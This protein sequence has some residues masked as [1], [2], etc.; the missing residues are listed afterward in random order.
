[1]NIYLW[2][3]PHQSIAPPLPSSCPPPP[4]PPPPTPPHPISRAFS[5]FEIFTFSSPTTANTPGRSHSH[6]V[7]VRLE[8][9]T[10]QPLLVQPPA[11]IDLLIG[12][13]S[14]VAMD[15]RNSTPSSDIFAILKKARCSNGSSGSLAEA[16]SGRIDM[17]VYRRSVVCYLAEGE[18][19]GSNIVPNL[20]VYTTFRKCL[21]KSSTCCLTD[22][23]RFT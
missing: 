20:R 14:L 23:I 16:T 11:P 1:M 21:S 15:P 17:V 8:V 4:P 10:E 22:G 12:A 7:C 6:D 13:Q 2:L 18:V 5:V 19:G 3:L 9:A